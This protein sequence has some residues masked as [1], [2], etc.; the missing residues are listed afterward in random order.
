MLKFRIPEIVLGALLAVAV[1]AMGTVFSSQP[2]QA[3]KNEQ[4]SKES[5]GQ[6]SNYNP[7]VRFWNWTSHDPVAFY[8][9][10]LAIF[11]GVLGATAIVQIRY[12]RKADETTRVAASAADRSARAAIALQLPIIGIRPD[13]LGHKTAGSGQEQIE[14][15]YVRVVTLTNLGPTKAFPK[16]ILYGWTFGDGLPAEPNYR[17]IESFLPNTFLEDGG[18]KNKR[19]PGLMVLKKGQWS[20]ICKGNRLWFYCDLL[21]EDFM[22]E[23]RSHGFCWRWAYTG[24]ALGWRIEDAPTYN[25]KT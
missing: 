1:F 16:E 18:P 25:R 15:C 12:L 2:A 17:Y 10:V 24:M 9:F 21:Y 13:E 20:E 4:P 8:T 14:S 19:L 3:P 11:T 23:R 6:A 5:K 7:F 22:G